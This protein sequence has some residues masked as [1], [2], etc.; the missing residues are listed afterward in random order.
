MPDFGAGGGFA[1]PSSNG[2]SGFRPVGSDGGDAGINWGFKP[3]GSG[4]P[5]MQAEGEEYLD[6]EE[7]ERVECVL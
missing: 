5:G 1:F 3:S 2:L 7:R 6:D 4:S